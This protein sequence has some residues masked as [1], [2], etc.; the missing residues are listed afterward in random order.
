MIR[1]LLVCHVA[2][3]A[4]RSS[5]AHSP[6]PAA[7]TAAAA[8]C[9][10]ELRRVLCRLDG[11][12][13]T[14]SDRFVAMTQQQLRKVDMSWHSMMKFFSSE[15]FDN[16]HAPAPPRRCA[17]TPAT[18]PTAA[19]AATRAPPLQLQVSIAAADQLVLLSR[20]PRLPLC[21]RTV[22]THTTDQRPIIIGGST[23]RARAIFL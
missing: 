9:P 12:A 20:L 23:Q 6:R 16:E 2:Q 21:T 15:E 8:C 14:C 1:F 13:D 19:T 10:G 5:S 22:P 17:A 11:E 7:A 18:R 4:R 3:P